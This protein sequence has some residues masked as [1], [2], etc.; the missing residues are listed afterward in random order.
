MNEEGVKWI[1]RIFKNIYDTGDISKEWQKSEF[2]A[3][4]KKIGAIG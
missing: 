2:I 4:T 1:I 3:L